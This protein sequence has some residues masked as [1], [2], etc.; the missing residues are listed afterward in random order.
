M[1]LII[2]GMKIKISTN[3]EYNVIRNILYFISNLCNK[4]IFTSLHYL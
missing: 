4:I 1:I 3:K 2:K